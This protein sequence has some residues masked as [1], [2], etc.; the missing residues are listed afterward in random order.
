MEQ[1]L[2]QSLQSQPADILIPDFWLPELQQE[3]N[4]DKIL[5]HLFVVLCH[6]SPKK[7]THWRKSHF[8]F[9]NKNIQ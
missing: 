4:N 8:Y 6:S 3:K 1:I 2:F 5:N 9:N 7:L